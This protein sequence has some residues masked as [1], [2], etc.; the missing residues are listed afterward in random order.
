MA[1]ET[2]KTRK[3]SGQLDASVAAFVPREIDTNATG[4]D[5]QPEQFQ[6]NSPKAELVS[7]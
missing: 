6:F 5:Q 4:P 1:G 2:Q 3:S 7:L